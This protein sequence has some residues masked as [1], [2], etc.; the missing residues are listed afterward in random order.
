MT[1]NMP[2]QG[3]AA[4][5][6]KRAMIDVHAALRGPRRQTRSADDPD[7]ARRAALRGAGDEADEMAA[8]VASGWS[9]PRRLPSRSRGCRHRR[10]LEGREGLRADG[11]QFLVL[12]L[13]LVLVLA[14]TQAPDRPMSKT[15]I[16]TET[17]TKTKTTL[18][19]RNGIPSPPASSPAPASAR[20]CRCSAR[21]PCSRRAAPSSRARRSRPGRSRASARRS[22]RSRSLVLVPR[23]RR[24]WS[25]HNWLVAIVYAATLVLFVTANKLT[26]SANAIFLQSTGPL[27]VMLA[28]PWLLREHV[29]RQDVSTWLPWRRACR[30]SSSRTSSRSRAHPTRSPA[31]SWPR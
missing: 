29:R 30:C 28:S 27:Y 14:W 18:R 16:K 15:R 22:P 25:L 17:G 31:T 20:G 9:T 1:V 5:I 19:R 21:R 13:V 8:L 7:G 6:L 24:H 3:T 26:T 10:E 23:A 11:A 12:V 4:D 2:I